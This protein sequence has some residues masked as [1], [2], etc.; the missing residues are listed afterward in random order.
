[1]LICYYMNMSESCSCR[2]M[3]ALRKIIPKERQE[4]INKLRNQEKA[5]KQLFSSA[6][7]Q[8]VLSKA[9]DLPMEAVAY[10]YGEY[11]KPEL[12]YSGKEQRG[13]IDFNL[14]HSGSYAVLAV[15]D[16]PVGIDVECLKK[17]RLTVAE[18][19]FC[20]KEYEDILKAEEGKRDSRFLE[21]WTMK[22]AYVKRTGKGLN[23]PLNHFLINRERKGFSSVDQENVYFAT[24]FLEEQKYCVSV[25][26][27]Y[28]DE[29]EKL[30]KDKMK[31]VK[32]EQIPLPYL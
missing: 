2:Q 22:E 4:K 7:L 1:M 5:K 3:E 8:Y 10:T 13:Q 20:E 29:I 31:E 12:I 15:S 27:E 24:F 17:N 6:F 14:S 26:S 11:G 19:F 21:Y 30:S 32:L 28:K 23:L 16:R 9:L 18:R 25:C